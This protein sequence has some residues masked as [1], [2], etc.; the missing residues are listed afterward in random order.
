MLVGKTILEWCDESLVLVYK[1]YK[2]RDFKER[3]YLLEKLE[4]L[5][6]KISFKVRLCKDMKALS[7]KCYSS[8]VELI[9]STESQSNSW[10]R[11][12]NNRSQ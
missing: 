4:E 3:A 9:K 10:K 1:A 6:Q 5:L 11:W 7:L 2:E 12:C 8:C